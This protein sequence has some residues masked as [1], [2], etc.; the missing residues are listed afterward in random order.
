MLLSKVA[1]V[2]P[3]SVHE[4][5]QSTFQKVQA[6]AVAMLGL[7]A[8]HSS[9]KDREGATC[10]EVSDDL[11]SPSLECLA[12]PLR[13]SINKMCRKLDIPKRMVGHDRARRSRWICREIFD[14][15]CRVPFSGSI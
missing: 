13:E 7:A 14:C 8:A 2:I 10:C 15:S 5:D 6:Q 11:R 4:G 1:S 9:G 12:W 3:G